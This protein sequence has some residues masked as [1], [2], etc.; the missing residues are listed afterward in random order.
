MFNKKVLCL[1]NN[2]QDT[3]LRTT[4]LAVQNHAINRGLITDSTFVPLEVGYYH[5]TII[6]IPSGMLELAQ[7][8]DQIILFD[9][10]VAQWTHYKPLLSSYKILVELEKQGKDT[11][12][13]NNNNVK[14]FIE[15]DKLLVENK[16][17]CIYPWI[18]KI[19]QNNGYLAPCARS[20]KK[21][22]TLEEL[23]DWRTDPNY[24]Y[25]RQKMLQG[26]LLPEHCDYCYDYERKGIESYREFET[27]EWVSK[28]NINSIEDLNNI[29]HPYYYELRLSNKC[30][31]MCRG[32][33]PGY[34][35]LIER[36]FKTHKINFKKNPIKYSSTD[37]IDIETLNK[38]VRVYLTGGEPTIMKEV[39]AFMRK[40]VDLGK[41]DFEFTLGTNAAK[42]SPA[43][44]E[45]S[46]QFS[47]MNFS[48]SLDGYGKINDYW[49]HGSDWDTVIKNTHILKSQGHSIN[50]NT[51]PGMYNV[52]NLHLLFEFLDREFPRSTAYLQINYNSFQSAYNHPNSKLVVESMEKCKQT[53][54]YYADGKSCKTCIDS[55]YDY[56]SN[57]PKCDLELLKKFFEHND[58]LDQA[59]N[60]RLADYIPE[61][62]ACRSLL[63]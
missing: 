50:I 38:D 62:E 47:N 63:V 15:F 14:N 32:C 46:S 26:E 55:L 16:S 37:I 60:V 25:V 8:F 22:T 59:R 4:N 35:H 36:E 1:G 51:V 39:I 49:R 41:T 54:I 28:L 2:D 21:I 13:K 9:Q 53:K 11:S 10:P 30:N 17:F 23:K 42:L 58:R 33:E 7:Q 31:I 24:Q 34:S 29:S 20:S 5:T 19:Q 48:V 52:T 43:F 18:E 3:D 45:L 6:D 56:Y 27:K 44:L 61:L 57:N 12:Y 40:C